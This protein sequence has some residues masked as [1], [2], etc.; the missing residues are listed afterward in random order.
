MIV[1]MENSSA[2]RPGEPLQMPPRTPPVPGRPMVF[3]L[4]PTFGE[5]VK[6]DLIPTIDARYRTLADRDHR[7]IAGL[8]LG[9]AFAL[10]VGLSN[11]DLFSSFGSFSGTVLATMDVKTSYGG[12][13]SNAEEFNKRVRLLFVA[14]GTEEVSRHKAAEHAMEQF[15][16]G[17]IHY[18]WY[19]SPGTDHE[20]L[21]WRRDLHEFAPLLFR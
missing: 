17:G 5:V 7:A 2:G 4:S 20:W 14:A 13:L 3:V 12:V 19:E 15:D 1:V 11:L 16:K 10:Q 8:S 18:V 6:K 21:T 9:A